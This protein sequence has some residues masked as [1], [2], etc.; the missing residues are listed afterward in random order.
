ME[1]ILLNPQYSRYL[2]DHM[3]IK[4]VESQH[5]WSESFI[6][7]F[8]QQYLISNKLSDNLCHYMS[9]KF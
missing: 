2:F 1:N 7:T 6:Q 5:Y 9:L 4:I 8:V 3:F